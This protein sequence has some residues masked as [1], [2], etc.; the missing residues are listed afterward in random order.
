MLQT[1]IN[2]LKQMHQFI[3]DCGD[4][5]LYWEWITEGIPDCPSE[6]DYISIASNID[7]WNEICHFFGDITKYY[8]DSTK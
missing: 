5:E 7:S 2:L 8:W 6:D 4:E 3:I 1:K